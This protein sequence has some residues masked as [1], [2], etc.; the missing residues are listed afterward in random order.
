[1]AITNLEQLT[2]LVGEESLTNLGE[3]G[4][5]QQQ[6]DQPETGSQTEQNLTKNLFVESLNGGQT[7]PT[8]PTTPAVKKPK[9]V[10]YGNP[11]Y[12]QPSFAG[13]TN[14]NDFWSGTES[15]LRTNPRYETGYGS[16]KMTPTKTIE[17]YD[18]QDYGYIYGI[19]NDDFYGKREAWYETLGKA[20]PRL[21]MGI[22]N[23]LG[24]GVGF[25]AGLVNPW[26]WGE[27]AYNTYTDQPGGNLIDIAA[28]NVIH[29]AFEASD[30]WTRN[31]WLPTFQ[32]A[33]D[34]NKGFWHRVATDADFWTQDFVD[35]LAFLASAWIPGAA[36]SKVGAGAALATRIGGLGAR[37]SVAAEAS[38]L[39]AEAASS[40]RWFEQTGKL[41]RNLDAFNSWAIATSSEAMFEAAEVRK[42][43]LDAPMYDEFGDP[44]INKKTG[45]P[46]TLDE[47]KQAAAQAAL[48]TFGMNAAV[49][50]ISN[51]FEYKFLKK[52]M[53]APTPVE[54]AG[55]KIIGGAI[56]GEEATVKAATPLWKT[57]AKQSFSGALREGFYE[58]NMQL[59]IQRYNTNYGLEGTIGNLLNLNTWLPL[60]KQYSKQ[61]VD[62]LLGDDKEAAMGIGLGGFI[63]SIFGTFTSNK[64]EKRQ[65]KVAEELAAGFNDAQNSF[66]KMGNV[67]KTEI[68][69]GVDAEGKPIKVQRTVFD[70]DGNPI[71]DYDK[72]FAVSGLM[73][74]NA[75]ELDDSVKELGK[76]RQELL[77][78]R[79]WANFVNAHLNAGLEGRLQEKLQALDKAD[80]ESLAKLGFVKDENFAQEVQKL[81][82]VAARIVKQN[83]EITNN[84]VFN[85]TTFSK[86]TNIAENNRRAHLIEING[87]QIVND[88]TANQV[89]ND[90]EKLKSK[91]LSDASTSLTDG[92]VDQLND[93]QYRI[94]SQ[95]KTIKAL[96]QSGRDKLLPMDIYDRVLS[97]L[98]E[99]YEELVKNNDLTV[100]QL[101]KDKNGLFRYE[102]ES[103][104]E[105]LLNLQLRE[106]SQTIGE[107][108]NEIA[109][110]NQLFNLFSNPSTGVENYSK[111][112]QALVAEKEKSVKEQVEKEKK[113]KA[114]DEAKA[115]FR[116]ETE[117]T[118]VKEA[119]GTF[120][121]VTPDGVV[122]VENIANQQEANEKAAQLTASLVAKKEAEKKAEQKKKEEEEKKKKEAQQKQNKNPPQK[123]QVNIDELKTQLKEK[124]D[125]AT[126][127]MQKGV[128]ENEAE[129][130]ELIQDGLSEDEA[131]AILEA[132]WLA[133]PDGQKYTQLENEINQ[134]KAVI[135]DAEKNNAAPA[136]EEYLKEIYN[137]L[138]SSP[139]F[140]LTYDQWY[141]SGAANAYIQ[142]YNKQYNKTE[143]LVGK[144]GTP[145]GRD[146]SAQEEID[147]LDLKD[148]NFKMLQSVT[149]VISK[150]YQKIRGNEDLLNKLKNKI[151]EI[152]DDVLKGA[153]RKMLETKTTTSEFIPLSSVG[154]NVPVQ[155]HFVYDRIN[156]TEEEAMLGFTLLG[157][158]TILEALSGSNGDLTHLVKAV[159]TIKYAIEAQAMLD[160]ANI[161]NRSL[162][163]YE[164]PKDIANLNKG[165]SVIAK[166]RPNEGFNLQLFLK[167]G[168]TRNIYVG[169]INRYAIVNPDNTTEKIEWTEAQRQFVMDNMLVDGKRMTNAQY[170][171][172]AEMHKKMQAFEQKVMSFLNENLES[173]ADKESIDITSLFKDTFTLTNSGGFFTEKGDSFESVIQKAA[174]TDRL[175]TVLVMDENENLTEKQV[176]LFAR[177][178]KTEW[179]Y[180]FLLNDGEY[181]VTRDEVG[182]VVP[183]TSIK[184]Y[185]SSIGV[186]LEMNDT[187][188]GAYAWLSKADNERGYTPYKLARTKG[189][190]RPELFKEFVRSFK[191]LKQSIADG[192]ASDD[193]IYRFEGKE[194]P[195]INQ[196]LQAFNIEHYGFYQY[197]GYVL[198]LSYNKNAKQDG[199]VVGK[200]LFEIRPM[201]K[202][203]RKLVDADKTVK[204]ALNMYISD[205]V[206]ME[207]ND[208]L[209]DEKTTELY[210]Q[211]VENLMR[212]FVKRK[213]ALRKA[214]NPYLNKVASE[215]DEHLMFSY[216]L[217]NNVKTYKIQLI[218]KSE[219]YRS[220]QFFQFDASSIKVVSITLTPESKF[221]AEPYSI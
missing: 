98:K 36:L 147:N 109:N 71:Y 25:V 50:G 221:N 151:E 105:P 214:N 176:P 215:L 26:N 189:T 121:I 73:L 93:L 63:G 84:V 28:D 145:S 184:E 116:K 3:T 192:L 165:L 13:Y 142:D 129:R 67:F 112:F 118:V 201:D 127:L 132:Q 42:S 134:L 65:Q 91:F 186:T 171:K 99:K 77:K 100:K 212:D 62:A 81:K 211:W 9:N 194:Y 61:T 76:Y 66:I 207:V 170:D 103:R 150:I 144:K 83:E 6:T 174:E 155:E 68:V 12:N 88:E 49:L 162:I 206:L 152:K 202:D 196:L 44:I 164:T 87:R 104:N 175:F 23:E 4:L 125:E 96:K 94:Q 179:V 107:L 169:G 139:D 58:E 209:S 92:I 2:S 43:I 148:A 55:S 54:G 10:S 34:N 191:A 200:F 180:S 190:E 7:D 143:P 64:Q 33:A 185:L 158:S 102:K 75:N 141:D 80:A 56:L 128:T 48:N 205:D 135:A 163:T 95:E 117:H 177:F 124:Q 72:I 166:F 173:T 210:K 39:A 120:T 218:K 199:K 27:A 208:D 90:L 24:K 85:N 197:K 146:A 89:K 17:R 156:M 213:E 57:L 21:G 203:Q 183:V 38:T 198:N 51:V 126:A 178:E 22:I 114:D 219:D 70:K 1:M 59:A 19:D 172:F 160:Q 11:A 32:E 37:V 131:D 8:K 111:F 15:Q 153:L 193:N 79:A 18:D 168:S 41:A 113:K 53:G 187:F 182:D 137:Q 161:P 60:A 110:D 97:S 188:P 119:D 5:D 101:K 86:K 52:L 20:V 159:A 45:K 138:T 46:F 140:K 35:G 40:A 30:E 195:N 167:D 154:V 149:R 181:L 74:T 69:D 31:E 47:R 29:K 130:Q 157:D 78:T 123:P 14:M 217:R 133:T 220:L 106:K 82:N 122:A 136:L 115:A 216:D 108:Q 204:K 16:S